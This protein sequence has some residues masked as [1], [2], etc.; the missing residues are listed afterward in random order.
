[1]EDAL[2]EARER[3]GGRS[4]DAIGTTFASSV[5]HSSLNSFVSFYLR[6]S[7]VTSDAIPAYN[8]PDSMLHL[9]AASDGDRVGGIA[10][11]FCTL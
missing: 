8:T 5:V 6:L 3:T 2:Q 1:M 9:S 10:W 11:R 4:M 7:A